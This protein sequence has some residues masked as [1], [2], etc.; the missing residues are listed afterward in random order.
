MRYKKICEHCKG[1]GLIAI[2]STK[3]T[4][5]RCNVCF[6]KGY[7]TS[8]Y[9][10]FTTRL[11]AD[12]DV[13]KIPAVVMTRN[14]PAYVPMIEIDYE[15]FCAGEFN[16]DTLKL[17]HEDRKLVCPALFESFCNSDARKRGTEQMPCYTIGEEGMNHWHCYFDNPYSEE[18]S[19]ECWEKYDKL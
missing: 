3:K 16:R 18:K 13:V 10:P 1:S 5:I 2:N 12:V 8:D 19:L 15:S 9:D 6:G 14:F 11:K 17:S 4:A 7:I